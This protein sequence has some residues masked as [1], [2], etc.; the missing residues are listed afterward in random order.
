MADTEVDTKSEISAKVGYVM[1]T[2][3]NRLLKIFH[4][5]LAS[6]IFRE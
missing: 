6:F 1:E 4:V 2:H 3:L 5:K